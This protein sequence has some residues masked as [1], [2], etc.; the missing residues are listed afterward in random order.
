MPL[1]VRTEQWRVHHLARSIPPNQRTLQTACQSR[2]HGGQP[3]TFRQPKAFAYLLLRSV[4]RTLFVSRRHLRIYCVHH[5]PTNL[6][7]KTTTINF[8]IG[9]LAGARLTC[10]WRSWPALFRLL[11]AFLLNVT[12][13]ASSCAWRVCSI[14][15]FLRVA[16]FLCSVCLEPSY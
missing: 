2:S 7:Q 12:K 3:D 1:A 5:H 16:C 10:L 9:L 6:K 8:K 13:R 11:S 15:I 4:S 14:A